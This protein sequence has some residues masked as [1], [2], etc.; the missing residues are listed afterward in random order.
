MR[1][2]LMNLLA[3]FGLV[4]LFAACSSDDKPDEPQKNIDFAGFYNGDLVVSFEGTTLDPIP[5]N[6]I[7]IIDKGEGKAK[8][9]LKNFSFGPMTL[10]DIIVDD[11]VVTT[12]GET[13][14]L[15]G[16]DNFKLEV[17][18]C[19]ATVEATIVNKKMEAKIFVDVVAPDGT[20]LKVDVLFNGEYTAEGYS[21]EAKLLTF[22]LKDIDAI[23][24]IEKESV[25]LNVKYADQDK[26]AK[27]L[28]VL[29][30]SEKATIS[31]AVDVEQDFTKPVV[32]TVT[33]EDGVTAVKYTVSASVNSI[34][35]VVDFD[36]STA[37]ENNYGVKTS[38]NI[39]A[40]PTNNPP[41]VW[42]SS[43]AGAYFTILMKYGDH[44]GVTHITNDE[45]FKAPVFSIETMNTKGDGMVPKITSG[46]LFLGTFKLDFMNTLKSTRFG[47]LVDKQPLA[48]LGKASYNSGKEYYNC[49]DPK[50]AG[51]ADLVEGKKDV[52]LISAV[53]YEVADETETLDGTNLY[54]SDK[55]IGIGKLEFADGFKDDFKFDVKYTKEFD[56]NKKYKLALVLSASKD[57]DKFSGAGGSVLK[58]AKL[59]IGFE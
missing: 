58:L 51:N 35:S 17:G 7:E 3:L 18:D 27:A 12:K 42:A 15:N 19:T 46:S 21:N 59:E 34:G 26:L 22:E 30:I 52:G 55:I 20:E 8:L 36:F 40:T 47:V 43:D 49:P 5:N 13:V 57:G 41:F 4:T 38:T 48:I 50:N 56:V 16:E 25:T 31:P 44:F 45:E 1:K 29:T 2:N 24:S 32:Y 53:V 28:P 23:S 14:Y 11:V 9:Q 6:K 39:S 54:S 37:V 10:G 33:A